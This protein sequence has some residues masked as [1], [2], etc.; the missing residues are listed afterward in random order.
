MFFASFAIFVFGLFIGS[1][2][3]AVVDRLEK[4]ESALRGRSYCPHCKHRLSWQDLIP[5]ASFLMLG[6]KCR[7]C[8]RRI[9]L[10]YPVIEIATGLIF[11][12][13]FKFQVS[14]FNQALSFETLNVFY[15]WTIASLLIVLFV[16]DLRH[17]ILPD[18]ILLP[19][20]GIVLGYRILE[21]LGFR[22]AWD[23]GFVVSGFAAAAFFLTIFLL[24]RGRAMGFG[25][26]K[27][28][29]FMGL[30]LG[31][32]N[33]LVALFAAFFVG[34]LVGIALIIMKKK[35]MRSEVPFGPFLI[36]GTFTAL[37]WGKEL[38]DW[39]LDLVLV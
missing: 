27:L 17:Y 32:P 25:D 38:V 23:L 24:S 16:Y 4:G 30:F 22:F 29:F 10:Q 8:K 6:G 31:W 13:S 3:N 37:W 36:G 34:A 2:L 12:L 39:Y 26:V 5:V 19:A 15:L 21:V 14:S 28:A 11:F 7:Y 18:K 9:S 1:F 20:I 35:A 33:I